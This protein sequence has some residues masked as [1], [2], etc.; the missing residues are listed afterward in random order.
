MPPIKVAFRNGFAPQIIAFC[1]LLVVAGGR[2]FCPMVSAQSGAFIE[3]GGEVVMEAE[4]YNGIISRSGKS[5]VARTDSAGYAGS[6]AMVAEPDTGTLN[7]VGYSSL[8]PE[9]QYQVQFSTPGTYK[10]WVR[11]LP[12][13]D[14][15]NSICVGLNGLEVATADRISTY[16]YGSWIWVQGTMDGPIATLVVPSAGT[17]TINVWMR[18]DGFRLDRLLL[19]TSATVPSGAGPAE[20]PRAALD[21]RALSGEWS[22]VQMWPYIAVHMHM[23]PTGQVMYYSSYENA[24]DPQL[25]DPTTSLIVDATK[26]GYNIF[27]TGHSFLPDGR[28]LIT[29]GHILDFVGLPNTFIY[30]PF[31][32]S[33]TRFPDM[34]AGRW[35]PTNT[36][37]ANGDVLVVSGQNDTVSGMNP[38]PQV[39]QTASGTWRDL[40]NALLVMPY[41]PYMFLAPNGKVFNAGPEQTTRYLNTSGSGTWTALTNSNFG[42]RNW[43]SAVMYDSGKILLVGGAHT[44]FY[45]SASGGELPT[46]TAEVIDLNAGTPRWRYVSSM[47]RPRKHLNTTILPDGKILATGGSSGS[48]GTNEMSIDPTYPAEV[49]DPATES[50]TTLASLSVY[51]GYHATALL[52]PDGRILSA[53]GDFGG[54]SYEIFSPPY[55]FKGARPIITVAPPTLSYGQTFFV[56]TPDATSINKVTL[57]RLSSVTHGFNMSQLINYL[58]FSQATGGLNITPPASANVS[59]PGYYMLFIL[60][61][62]GV[63]SVGKILRIGP[64]ATPA[65]PSNLTAIATSSSQINLTWTDSAVNE[66]GFKIER[67]QGV[68]CANFSQITTVGAGAT[69]YSNT[70]LAAGTTY[71]YRV[72]AYNNSGNSPYSNTASATSIV[73]ATG[74]GLK[75]EYYDNQDFTVLK[76]TRVDATVNFAWGNGSPHASVASDTFSVRWTGQ[77]QA[78]YSQSYTFYTTSD[79]GVRLWINGQL[80]INNWT[81]HGPT[82]NSGTITLVANQRY[83]IKM[84]YY[85]NGGGAVAKLSWSSA[86]QP[87]QVIPQSRLFA[88]N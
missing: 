66:T 83:D 30:D 16:T 34:N 28:L 58:S 74:T 5:W 67:C 75:G 80:I 44:A 76:L 71:S 22:S 78:Q 43:G 29:G 77:V 24:D 2:D 13:N 18:E 79:D 73:I 49:W 17:Y 32:N 40:T 59:P 21:P 38:L 35:Y 6:A 36:T 37:L 70:G 14:T 1:F 25:W 61:S 50:W 47:N 48:E 51:R 15:N 19:T 23:L 3:Q 88:A 53:S 60:N 42:T 26:A 10:V 8:S 55:L 86:S 33:W 12:D 56:Q 63:P 45:G 72:R 46:A 31:A 7:D 4:S 62:N 9:M 81:D 64:L 82:E 57:I 41:Y 65:A 39:F 69:S 87:K 85:E 68:G 11:Q 52:L 27:C 54:P 20:S 84:E